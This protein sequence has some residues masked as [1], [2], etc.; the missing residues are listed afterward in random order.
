M[1][2]SRSIKMNWES[3]TSNCKKNRTKIQWSASFRPHRAYNITTQNS[4]LVSKLPKIQWSA[5]F[6]PHRAYNIVWH[7][8]IYRKNCLIWRKLIVRLRPHKRKWSNWNISESLKG[9]RQQKMPI[10]CRFKRSPA[11]WN[12][13]NWRRIRRRNL[14]R[15][16]SKTRSQKAFRKR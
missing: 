9:H 2:K 3:F 12:C 10:I 1:S 11:K 5:S 15:D 4:Q 6:R 16:L 14:S 8:A 7:L 13:L